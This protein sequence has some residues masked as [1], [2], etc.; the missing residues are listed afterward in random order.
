VVAQKNDSVALEV[1]WE[2]E[3]EEKVL[4]ME[5]AG[6]DCEEAEVSEKRSRRTVCYE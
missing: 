6:L 1:G 2:I 3:S 4:Q 5:M